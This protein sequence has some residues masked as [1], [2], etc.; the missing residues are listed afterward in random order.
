MHDAGHTAL[1]LKPDSHAHEKTAAAAHVDGAEFH[2]VRVEV[3]LELLLGSQ[4][5]QPRASEERERM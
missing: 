1:V 5:Q 4:L 2:A 3:E